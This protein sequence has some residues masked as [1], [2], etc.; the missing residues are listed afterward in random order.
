M[1]KKL[2]FIL[3]MLY[4]DEVIEDDFILHEYGLEPVSYTHLDVYKRQVCGIGVIL[5]LLIQM[6]LHSIL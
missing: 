2:Y 6:V 3:S 5:I 1:E 4:N